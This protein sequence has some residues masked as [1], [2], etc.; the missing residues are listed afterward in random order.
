MKTSERRLWKVNCDSAVFDPLVLS[1]LKC[2]AKMRSDC[3]I[4]SFGVLTILQMEV[5]RTYRYLNNNEL[6]ERDEKRICNTLTIMR[7]LVVKPEIVIQFLDCRR[8]VEGFHI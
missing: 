4:S 2:D 1:E 5:L 6:T 3:I 8:H 7:S